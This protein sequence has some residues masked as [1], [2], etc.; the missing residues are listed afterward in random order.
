MADQTIGLLQR[1]Q[2]LSHRLAGGVCLRAA[3]EVGRAYYCSSRILIQI[4]PSMF[5]PEPSAPAPQK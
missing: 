4:L 1:R 2:A 5:C 3:G